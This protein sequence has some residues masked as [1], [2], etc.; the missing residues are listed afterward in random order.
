[1]KKMYSSIMDPESNSL[2]RLPPMQRFQITTYLGLMWTLIFCI[3]SGA[4]FWFGH[5]AV[6][7]VGMAFG[8]LVTGWT[9]QNARRSGQNARKSGTYRDYPREDGTARYDDVWGA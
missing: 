3:G 8:F 5:L 9:F 7:H 4:W 1:M 6:L 2:N